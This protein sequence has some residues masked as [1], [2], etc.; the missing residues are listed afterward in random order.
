MLSPI[1]IFILIFEQIF[2]IIKM[3]LI[4]SATITVGGRAMS[5]GHRIRADRSGSGEA[6][7]SGVQA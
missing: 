5:S 1:F 7:V 4:T 6:F 3:V 2:A